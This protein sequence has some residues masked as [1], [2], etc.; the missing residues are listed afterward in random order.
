MALASI[1][2][3]PRS[4]NAIFLRTANMGNSTYWTPS[5]D[6]EV[7]LWLCNTMGYLTLLS[8]N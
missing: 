6:L 1:S 4:V 8:N 7:L 2:D 5:T 3:G